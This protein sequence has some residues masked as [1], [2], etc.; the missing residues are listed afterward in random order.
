M[1]AS[2]KRSVNSL[3]IQAGFLQG[4]EIERCIYIKSPKEANTNG[5]WKLNKGV[6]G[7]NDASRPW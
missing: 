4:N 6:Y 5:I 1:L 3:D 2:T 7:L